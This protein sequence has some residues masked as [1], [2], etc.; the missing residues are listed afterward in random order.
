MKME[1]KTN[2]KKG[3]RWLAALC[4]VTM[5]AGCLWID[6]G[7]NASAEAGDNTANMDSAKQA[8]E[9]KYYLANGP[10]DIKIGGNAERSNITLKEQPGVIL[11]ETAKWENL[12][13]CIEVKFAE[14]TTVESMTGDCVELAQDTADCAEISC[15]LGSDKYTSEETSDGN[16][17]LKIKFS[18]LAQFE[19]AN[20]NDNIQRGIYGSWFTIDESINYFRIYEDKDKGNY[21]KTGEEDARVTVQKVW[22]EDAAVAGLEFGETDT[23][24]QLTNTLSTM[25]K[26]I[27]ASVKMDATK[28]ATEWKISDDEME[29][30]TATEEDVSKGLIAGEKYINGDCYNTVKTQLGFNLSKYELEDLALTFD[31]V[32][33]NEGTTS[34]V[35]SG[36]N[37]RISNRKD[38]AV[39]YFLFVWNINMEPGSGTITK[40]LSEFDVPAGFKFTLQRPVESFSIAGK[41]SEGIYINNVKLISLKNEQRSL[42]S[43]LKTYKATQTDVNASTGVVLGERYL[44]ED[45]SMSGERR[46]LFNLDLRPYNKNNLNFCVNFGYKTTLQEI[47]TNLGTRYARLSNNYNDVSDYFIH[48]GMNK[49]DWLLADDA[50]P[51]QSDRT[52]L[53]KADM[54]T[55]VSDNWGFDFTKPVQTINFETGLVNENLYVKDFYL[56]PI[57]EKWVEAEIG[58]ANTLDNNYMIFSNLRNGANDTPYALFITN[59]GYPSV[60][61]GQKQFVYTRSIRT[62]EWVDLAAVINANDTVSLYIDGV[63]MGTSTLTVDKVATFTTPHSIGADASGKQVMDGRIADVRLWN[64]ART[65]EEISNS[66]ITK[67]SGTL[68]LELSDVEGLTN[69]WF[70]VGDSEYVVQDKND[71]I[72]G[73]TAVYRGTRANTWI[74]YEKPEWAKDSEQYWS[75]VYVGGIQN[76]T[77]NKRTTQVW[78]SMAQWIVD[79]K[80][81][82]K[83]Q[84]VISAGA[85]VAYADDETYKNALRGYNRYKDLVS[86]SIMKADDADTRYTSYFGGTYLNSSASKDTYTGC[87]NNDTS[88][89]YYRFDV[90]GVKWMVLQLGYAPEQAVIDWAKGIADAHPT[91]NIILT[92]HGYIKADSTY[93]DDTN[94]K[95]IWTTLNECS[96]IKI[97]LCSHAMA[98]G[99]I[100]TKTETNTAGAAVP[101][102][103]INGEEL[104]NTENSYIQTSFYSDA[105]LGMLSILRFKNDGSEVTVQY[106]SPT[107]GKS[108]DAMSNSLNYT[109]S[110]ETCTSYTEEYKADDVKKIRSEE[111]KVTLKA[112]NQKEEVKEGAGAIIRTD[113]VATRAEFYLTQPVDLSS[114]KDDG[115]LCFWF[116]IDDP[117]KLSDGKLWVDLGEKEADSI[118]WGYDASTLVKGWNEITLPLKQ[119]TFYIV[120]G[121][122]SDVQPDLSKVCWFRIPQFT[123]D[124]KE[125]TTIVD[126][127]RMVNTNDEKALISSCDNDTD[128]NLING[129]IITKKEEKTYYKADGINAKKGF[130]FAGWFLDEQ[131]KTALTDDKLK[132]LDDN[133]T[134]WAKFIDKEILSVKAQ[135]SINLLNEDP[136][137]DSTGG[138]RFVSSIDG[139]NYQQT[140][141]KLVREYNNKT[142]VAHTSSTK[143]YSYVFENDGT[144]ITERFAKDVFAPNSKFFTTFSMTNIASEKFDAQ[145]SATAYIVT[146]DGTIVYGDTSIKCIAEQLQLWA[147]TQ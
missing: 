130:A 113:N 124:L 120:G 4:C 84:H 75:M 58:D 24:L 105:P 51:L 85:S 3:K 98:E 94:I 71:T 82:E 47:N 25:P 93:I 89:S 115:A 92:T 34:I 7:V 11:S 144:E 48:F 44:H 137:D 79:N 46:Q 61:I 6:S 87:Y 88:N 54:I 145:Y 1:R 10:E 29:N 30:Y 90:N 45:E 21:Y 143:A 103:M 39:D 57:E 38:D 111:N 106:Y 133:E 101:V 53:R 100:V 80:D 99:K 86:N 125:M 77:K 70:L 83:I 22:I 121:Q 56:E 12:S 15:V 117:S 28:P 63:C 2:M 78:E 110:A 146:K 9:S 118:R 68:K 36:G 147:N 119:K 73:N 27:E 49:F 104:D 64:D 43:D 33:T 31:Y 32:N 14:G 141:F 131:C 134:I 129:A 136:S 72:G 122:V 8:I 13:L 135:L 97:I 76:L 66:R 35:E 74:D 116:Y 128:L 55:G 60:V 107:E 65:Q 52:R 112:F 96:N 102:L 67:T 132:D 114:Y 95:A 127:I 50:S 123:N 23:H 108:Y 40:K 20:T 26:T 17:V 18:N 138:I 140:G 142:S 91:D 62:G 69:S 5:L 81:S 41:I 126:D 37:I 109:I 42:I 19:T 16:T 59:D 139:R